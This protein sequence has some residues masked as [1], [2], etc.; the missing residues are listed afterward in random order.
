MCLCFCVSFW[1]PADRKGTKT[2]FITF[3]TCGFW[4]CFAPLVFGCLVHST[5]AVLSWAH[6]ACPGK[7]CGAGSG[8]P[9]GAEWAQGAQPGEE[10][11]VGTPLLR[12]CYKP[13]RCDTWFCGGA[14][15]A[16]LDDLRGFSKLN[17]SVISR[18]ISAQ[19]PDVLGCWSLPLL[20]PWKELP[21]NSWD[22]NRGGMGSNWTHQ[23]T[24][25]SFLVNGDELKERKIN[26]PGLLCELW[27]Q[28][29]QIVT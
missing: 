18:I 12:R 24:N 29:P 16:G 10:E 14:G 2:D 21:S 11:A 28:K 5:A 20:D 3:I 17:Y 15:S 7:G 13:R 6:T 23:L 4:V 8:A 9:G 27:W 26:H 25:D 1:L 19:I 22:K